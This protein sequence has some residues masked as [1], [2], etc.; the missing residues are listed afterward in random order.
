MIKKRKRSA[1]INN[2]F[3]HEKADLLVDLVRTGRLIETDFSKLAWCLI[4]ELL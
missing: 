3:A 4:K 2:E 1:V